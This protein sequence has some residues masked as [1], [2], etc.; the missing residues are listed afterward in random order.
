MEKKYDI[1]VIGSGLGGL[2]AGAELASKR[3]R[4]LILEQHFQVGGSA[5]SF[6]RKGF[7]Y[8]AGL[9]MTAEIDSNNEQ[10][11]FFKKCGLDKKVKFVPVPEFYHFV[12][13]DYS[14]TFSNDVEDNIKRLGEMFPEDAK[15]VKKYFKT[16]FSIHDQAMA[17][18]ELKGVKFFFSLLL[19]PIL[20]PKVLSSMFST[21]GKF[22]D[23]TIKDER[24]KA[25][26]LGNIG[27]Y[28]DDAHKLSFLFYA[29]AQTGFYRKGGSYIQGGSHQLP[30]ALAEYIEKNN[31]D[32]LTTQQVTKII[33]ENGVAIGVEYISKRKDAIK[34]KAYAPIIIANTAIP[35]VTDE[36]IEGKDALPLKKKYGKLHI[37]PSIMTVYIA[38]DKPLKEMGNTFYSLNYYEAKDFKIKDMPEINRADFTIRPYILCDYSQVDSRLAPDGKGYLVLSMM[39]YLEDWKDLSEEEYKAKKERAGKI[40]LERVCKNF[41]EMGDHVERIE[42]ATARTMKRYL[43]TPGG[44]AYGY[45]QTPNQAILF[46]PGASSPIKN[47]YFASA[48][49]LPGAGFGGAMS[50]GHICAAQIKK[51]LGIK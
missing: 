34:S 15:G 16:I 7:T 49:T 42:V 33:M 51:D 3:K 45:S 11:E 37:A 32:I 19:S 24:L 1:I 18:N 30:Y 23:H 17:I 10:Y 41:P 13:H 48:W 38:L 36:L 44:T 14:Y 25:I 35:N 12:G 46:R 50:A 26:L 40:M 2:T 20:F 27:Y 4:V 47:L 6:K 8:E 39:D 5:T 21:I 22:L 29:I 31:G 43:Q 9:H 28:G